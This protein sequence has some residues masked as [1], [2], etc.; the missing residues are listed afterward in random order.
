MNVKDLIASLQDFDPELEV[1]CYAVDEA[2]RPPGHLFR[3]MD[4]QR[5]LPSEGERFK[6]ADGVPTISFGHTNSSEQVVFLHVTPE[7]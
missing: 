1:F 4:V 6:G 2:L 7:F 3:L 5:V